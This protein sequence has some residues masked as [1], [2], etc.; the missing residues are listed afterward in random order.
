MRPAELQG[1]SE[2]S[3]IR[4]DGSISMDGTRQSGVEQLIEERQFQHGRCFVG[5]IC[6]VAR[7]DGRAAAVEGSCVVSIAGLHRLACWL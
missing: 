3:G 5:V 2:A 6:A 1:G 4:C 7:A